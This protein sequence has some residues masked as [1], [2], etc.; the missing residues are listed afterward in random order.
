[1][2][3]GGVT[4]T[5]VGRHPN[6]LVRLLLS[7]RD[8][9]LHPPV[10][11]SPPKASTATQLGWAA[12]GHG[13]V[14]GAAAGA[15]TGALIGATSDTVIWA[16]SCTFGALV[17]AVVA[18]LPALF[19]AELVAGVARRQLLPFDPAAAAGE[20]AQVLAWLLV[21]LAVLVVGAVALVVVNA[22]DLHAD[23]A[24]WTAATIATA[25]LV[26]VA[27]LRRATLALTRRLARAHGW[28]RI[29]T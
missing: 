2:L 17:G 18:V 8:L 20:L 15:A 26:T 4:A 13:L 23:S 14:I 11:S 9:E 27:L 1:M 12:F 10:V 16:A 7:R 5:E 24:A 19:G 21:A 6:A 22:D 3:T 25:T 29:T 28:T